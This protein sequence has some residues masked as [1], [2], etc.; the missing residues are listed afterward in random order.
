MEGKQGEI[1]AM[2]PRSGDIL[3]MVSH[4]AFDPNDFAVHI[5]RDE[6]NQLVTDP[7]KPLLNKAIQA[8][9][10]PGSTFKIL[11]SV[12]GLQE[13]IAQK[14]IVNCGGGGTFYGRFFKC[15]TKHGRVDISKG[16]YAS[17]DTYYYTLGEKL[18]IG[19]IAKYAT[20]FGLRPENRHRF[21]A[22][23]LA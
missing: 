4:P 19:K 10:A 20:E 17:C 16:I 15:D 3:A 14:L 1:V 22:G 13:G 21:T 23:S 12:A 6:W 5:S 2:D 18:G 9:L 7:G 11:M 8:Q